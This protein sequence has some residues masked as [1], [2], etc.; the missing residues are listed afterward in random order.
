M[1]AILRTPILSQLQCDPK[2]YWAAE[3]YTDWAWPVLDGY[4][5]AA[6]SDEPMPEDMNMR[7]QRGTNGSLT[8]LSSVLTFA[9]TAAQYQF[10]VIEDLMA[11]NDSSGFVVE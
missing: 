2:P 10:P 5:K 11:R 6:F 1:L 9:W 4:S 8:Y 7:M 3:V